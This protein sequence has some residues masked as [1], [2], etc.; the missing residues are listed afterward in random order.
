MMRLTLPGAIVGAI[1]A[2]GVAFAAPPGES[3]YSANCSVCHQAA[4]AGVP[5]SFPRLAGRSGVLAGVANGRKM[6]IFAVLY[7]MA[8]K[9]PVDG[10]SILGVMTPLP[11]LSDADIAAILTYVTHLDHQSPKPFTA[12]EVAAIRSQPALTS[13]QVNALATDEALIKLA[14]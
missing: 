6:M 3:L 7:G 12:A 14:P 5:G 10:Q 4:G 13:S 9:M 11:Q 8:G 1:L 2:H